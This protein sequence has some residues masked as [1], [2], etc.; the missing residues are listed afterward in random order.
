MTETTP[1][2]TEQRLEVRIQK[3]QANQA[4]FC[5]QALLATG[6]VSQDQMA[7]TLNFMEAMNVF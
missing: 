7:A 5:L 4:I 3:L 6:R 1:D 2:R